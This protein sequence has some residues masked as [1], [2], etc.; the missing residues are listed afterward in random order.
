MIRTYGFAE[1]GL[2]NHSY[3]HGSCGSTPTQYAV[4]AVTKGHCSRLLPQLGRLR[5]F[6]LYSVQHLLRLWEKVFELICWSGN[7]D[8][9]RLIPHVHDDESVFPLAIRNY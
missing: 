6:P 2:L 4:R 9:H 3:M 7:V 8:D 1:G 5:A